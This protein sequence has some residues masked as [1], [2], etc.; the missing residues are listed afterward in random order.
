MKKAKRGRKGFGGI[1]VM[2]HLTQEILDALDKSVKANEADRLTR[3]ELIRRS[4]EA[5]YLGRRRKA[6][7]TDRKP[8]MQ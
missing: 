3:A 6:D 4:L 1:R 8:P 2:V 7:T 5:T